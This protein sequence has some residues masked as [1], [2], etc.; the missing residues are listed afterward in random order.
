MMESECLVLRAPVKMMKLPF[1]WKDS[2]SC[3]FQWLGPTG[4]FCCF[5]ISALSSINSSF[6]HFCQRPI[7][8]QARLSKLL[9]CTRT[10]QAKKFHGLR[11]VLFLGEKM[12]TDCTLPARFFAIGIDFQLERISGILS[13]LSLWEF[14]S[15]HPESRWKNQPRVTGGAPFELQVVLLFAF[16]LGQCLSLGRYS[17]KCV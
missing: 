9:A 6:N 17:K 5:G 12:W 16:I 2:F 13:C 4:I 1:S 8:F 14:R 7:T 3:T 10:L 11:R 15:K